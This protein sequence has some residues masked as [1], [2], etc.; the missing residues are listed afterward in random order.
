MDRSLAVIQSSALGP[1]LS[2]TPSTL[3]RPVT[4]PGLR[5]GREARRLN[6]SGEPLPFPRRAKGRGFCQ[7]HRVAAREMLIPGGGELRLVFVSRAHRIET[8]EQVIRARP[9]ILHF[10]RIGPD[11]YDVEMNVSPLFIELF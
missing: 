6:L 1:G 4:H 10:G 7:P 5:V 8:G 11:M 9:R 2:A 3:S